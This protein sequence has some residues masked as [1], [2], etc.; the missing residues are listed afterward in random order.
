VINNALGRDASSFLFS[1][2][3]H[4]DP[5]QAAVAVEERVDGYELNMR[6]SGLDHARQGMGPSSPVTVLDTSAP[7]LKGTPGASSSSTSSRSERDD[8]VPSIW[9][10]SRASRRT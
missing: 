8:P 3:N 7:S 5:A 4:S 9:E 1:E 6:Q 10:D 2:S